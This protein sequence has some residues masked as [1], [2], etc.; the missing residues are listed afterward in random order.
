MDKETKQA[1]EDSITHWKDNL[2]LAE[3]GRF[4]SI[5]IYAEDCALCMLYYY[6]HNNKWTWCAGCPVSTKVN[7]PGCEK[8]PWANV[9][10]FLNETKEQESPDEELKENLIQAIKKEIE[11]LESLRETPA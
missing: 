10:H 6:E 1:L 2:A 11:F 8:T 4:H 5:F 3:V 9:N 7:E